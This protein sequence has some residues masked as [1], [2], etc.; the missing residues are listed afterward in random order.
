MRANYLLLYC[1]LLA[2]SSA[3]QDR[4]VARGTQDLL[5]VPI[6]VMPFRANEALLADELARREPG[7][8]PKFA[9]KFATSINPSTHGLWE[10][11]PG[12]IAVWRLAIYSA[13]AKSLNL[14]FTEFHMP[15]EGKM[16]LYTPDKRQVMGPFSPADYESH[17]QLWT[18][19]LEGDELVIEVQ[20]PYTAKQGLKLQ[21]SAISHDFLGFA[22]I[23]SGECNLDVACGSSDGWGIVE[24]YRDVIRS[25]ANIGLLG[26]SYCTGYLVSNTRNDQTPYFIT[27]DHCGFGL[28]NAATLVAYWGFENSSCRQPGGGSSGGGGD[29]ALETYNSGAFFRAAYPPADVTLLELDDPVPI[30]AAPFMA[31][32][33][34][35]NTPTTDTIACIHHPNNDEKRISFEFDPTY[36]GTW[37]RDND[38]VP[39]GN[40]LIVPDWDIGTTEGG[41]SGAPLVNKNQQVIGQLHGGYAACGYD[42]YD[43]FGR[44]FSA[45]EGGGTPQTRLKDWLDP[46]NLGALSW[47][48]RDLYSEIFTEQT[49]QEVCLPGV[50]TYELQIGTGFEGPVQLSI[51][52]LPSGVSAAFSVNPVGPGASTVLTLDSLASFPVGWQSLVVEGDD[53]DNTKTIELSLGLFSAQ[54][55]APSPLEPADNAMDAPNRVAFSWANSVDAVNYEL[56]LSLS[57]TFDNLVLSSGPI[58]ATTFRSEALESLTVYYWRIRSN[59]TCGTGAWSAV[60]SFTTSIVVCDVGSSQNNSPINIPSSGTTTLVSTLEVAESMTIADVQVENLTIRHSWVGDLEVELE[61]PDG[62]TVRLFDR[63]GGG[64]CEADDIIASFEDNASEPYSSFD[65]SCNLN[66]TGIGGTFQPLE[67][68]SLFSGKN[69]QGTWKLRLTDHFDQDGGRLESWGLNF[70]ATLPALAEVYPEFSLLEACPDQTAALR[71]QTGTGYDDP[72]NLSVTGLPSGTTVDIQPNPVLPGGFATIQVTGL[73]DLGDYPAQVVG[74]DGDATDHTA[75]T[76]RVIDQPAAFASLDPSAGAVDVDPQIT[77]RWESSAFADTYRLV[78]HLDSLTGA[79]AIEEVLTATEYSGLRSASRTYH[80]EVFAQN[81]CG[82]TQVDGGSFRTAG[83]LTFNAIP[84]NLSICRTR[85]D[86]SRINLGTGFLDP[87]QLSY[88]STPAGEFDL[89]YDVDPSAVAPGSQVEVSITPT[90][91]TPPGFYDLDFTAADGVHSTT[92]TVRVAVRDVPKPALLDE[93]LEAATVGPRPVF[94]WAPLPEINFYAIQIA[95]DTAFSDL[96]ESTST[97]T[98]TYPMEEDLAP[99]ETY[100]WRVFAYN[101]CGNDVS[102]IRGFSTLVTSTQE[103]AAAFLRLH[104]N[105]ATQDVYLDWG[106]ADGMM[107]TRLQWFNASGQLLRDWEVEGVPQVVFSVANDPNGIYWLRLIRGGDTQSVRVIVQH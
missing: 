10:E 4:R 8:A 87:V 79:V 51:E 64:D 56:E 26:D 62:T 33:D 7:V 49:I 67:S 12:G 58:N 106:A 77:F 27:A 78:I 11:I 30:A 39:N 104:P 36:F 24:G 85:T 97:T 76:F 75:V 96:V 73:S 9:H 48:G 59:N 65:Q 99:G 57:P 3:A 89:V 6:E 83:P 45:W 2:M 72:V 46:E 17:G 21:L 32:W 105:P 74:T 92:I 34:I 94:R 63:P 19:I 29:G 44:L 38:Y 20:V 15:K 70:C 35:T 14:G 25:V 18:P 13:G 101:N 81:E 88:T 41:S 95:R 93:P 23:A 16:L 31:G 90:G 50:L 28:N 100:Y 52:A 82:E 98:N 66:G 5:A 86:V 42:E 102:L 71:V 1:M 91:M 40:H 107:A 61:G 68:L 80:W 22:Q 37:E 47:A 53:G 43:S 54:P 69:A 84:S 55:S 103:P 60:R